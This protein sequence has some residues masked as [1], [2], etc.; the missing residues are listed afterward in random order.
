MTKPA[1][2]RPADPNMR[3]ASIMQD[4]VALSN[5]PIVAPPI[6]KAKR[7]KPGLR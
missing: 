3:M 4:V 5:K 1:K 2:K 7:R 6:K